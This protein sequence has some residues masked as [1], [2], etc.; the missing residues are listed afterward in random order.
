MTPEAALDTLRAAGDAQ[1]A[2]EMA[3]YHKV[4]RVY[5]GVA[6]PM[7]DDLTRAWRADITLDER[8]TL[9][10]GLWDSN[11]HEARVAAAKLLTQAR[12]RP[13]DSGAWSLIQTWV[14]DFDA[15]AI[16]DH[17]RIAGQKRLV[18][19]P[20]RINDIE[21]WTTSDHMWTRRAALVITLPWAKKNKIKPADIDIRER[22]LGWAA[23]YVDDKEWFMQK[24]VAWWL[25]DLSKHDAERVRAFLDQHGDRMKA[26]ARKEAA[27]YLTA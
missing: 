3:A 23:T 5:L 13:D 6:N 14:P 9:A 7:I 27:K 15:W 17:A 11:S 4:D 1:K 21:P 12:I 26:F 22:I 8:L 24:V 2:L 20:E 19:D 16:A 18:A 10:Q 25:R